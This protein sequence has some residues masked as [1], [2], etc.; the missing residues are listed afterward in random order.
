MLEIPTLTKRE[1]QLLFKPKMAYCLAYFQ[2]PI[3]QLYIFLKAIYNTKLQQ[4][5]G[6][7]P[8]IK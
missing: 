1:S 7:L 6:D 8:N 2:Y 5:L 4:T 3:A